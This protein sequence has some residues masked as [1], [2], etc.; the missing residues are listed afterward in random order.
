MQHFSNEIW[1]RWRKEFLLSLQEKQNWSSTRRNQQEDIVILKDDN[2][3]RNEWKLAK[4]IE[5]FPEKKG[6]A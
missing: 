1:N 4:V 3:K 6:F 2:C 5:T